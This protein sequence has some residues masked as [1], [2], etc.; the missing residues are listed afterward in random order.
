M[1]RFWKIAGIAASVVILGSLALGA[2]ALAQDPDDGQDWPFNFRE[3]V[4]QAVADILGVE[5]EEYDAAIEQA[6]EQVLGEAVSEGWLT[7][8]QADR[9]R[10]RQAEGFGPRGMD[11][12]FFGPRRGFMGRGGDP[13]LAVAADELGMTASELMD[14]LANGKS[15]AGIAEEKGVDTQAIVDAHQAK[16]AETLA[17]AVENG[18]ITQKQADWM[19]EQIQQ[20]ITDMLEKTWE[21]FGPRRGPG[22]MWDGG[23]PGRPG[24]FPGTIEG[25]TS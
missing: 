13:F 4:H 18:R 9:M 24:G 19:L 3:R 17:Q 16:L 23:G 2:I 5:V 12:G 10:E 15:I 8:E 7:Q 25:T 21:D 11:K 20:R 14:E 1:S 6:Q 22:R